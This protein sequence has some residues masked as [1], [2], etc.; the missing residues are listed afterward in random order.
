MKRQWTAD[1]LAEH[2]TLHPQELDLLANKSGA[3]RL[4]FAVLLKYFQYEGQFP[5][6]KSDI[7]T[8]LG[9]M[10]LHTYRH[11]GLAKNRGHEPAPDG[12]D[13]LLWLVSPSHA[14]AETA[15]NL[16]TRHCQHSCTIM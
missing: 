5:P 9:L 4:G 16:A 11:S 6:H 15:R 2:W 12:R 10:I 13:P 7:P 14:I 3:T 1:E 8:G